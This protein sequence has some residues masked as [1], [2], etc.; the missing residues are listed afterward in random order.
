M[1]LSSTGNF[2]NLVNKGTYNQHYLR[3]GSGEGS[4]YWY[5]KFSDGTATSIDGNTG[6]KW[7]TWHHLVATVDT[8][9]RTI[10]VYLAG[11]EKLSG[12]FAAGKSIISTTNPLLVSDINQRWVK[13]IIDEIRISNITRSAAWIQTSYNNQKDP[14]TFHTIGGE[15]TLSS[16]PLIFEDPQNEATDIYTNPTLSARITDPENNTMTIIFKEKVAN[17]WIDIGIYEN[18]LSGTYSVIA[19]QMKNLGTTY[20]W[21][22]SINK[23][24]AWTN[25]TFSLTTTTKILQQKWMV[26]TGYGGVSGVLAADVNGDGVEEVIHAGLRGVKVLNGIDGSILWNVSD[27]GVYS[28]AQPQMTDLNRDNIL[29]IIVPLETPAGLLVLHANNGS[30]YWRL[31]SGLGKET[32]SGPVIFDIDGNGYPTI[33]VGST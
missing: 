31:Q 10:K 2:I 27:S 29:E 16:A 28:G 18:V 8:Q 19:T 4:I 33:F 25:K 5:V 13:G 32:Y 17:S 26:K 7:N 30:T 9:A 6:W 21:G 20:Y 1:N 11:V 24:E 15:E 23:G 14:T 22:V 12:T 3:A